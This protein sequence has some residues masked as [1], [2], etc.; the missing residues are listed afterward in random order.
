ME[1]VKKVFRAGSLDVPYIVE[2]EHPMTIDKRPISEM[3]LCELEEAC[4]DDTTTEAERDRILDEMLRQVN[5]EVHESE[6]PR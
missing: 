4:C 1:K 2:E 5:E 6:Q 3:S